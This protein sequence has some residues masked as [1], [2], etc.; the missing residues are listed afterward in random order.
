[1]KRQVERPPRRDGDYIRQMAGELA[2][3]ARHEGLSM[4]AFLLQM[5]VLEVSNPSKESASKQDINIEMVSCLRE[6]ASLCVKL[7][8]DCPDGPTS[9]KLEGI[10][11]EIMLKAEE[12]EK[13]LGDWITIN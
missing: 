3:M 1:M 13:L 10:G 6:Q 7:A 12:L 11:T 2:E 8:R 4:V 9:H 5:A